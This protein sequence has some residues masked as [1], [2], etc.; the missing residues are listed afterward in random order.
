MSCNVINLTFRHVWSATVQI[1]Q[2][3]CAVWSKSSLGTFWIAKDAKFLHVN[4]KV[5][6]QT[7]WMWKLIRV[8]IGWYV[9]SLS[10]HIFSW[11]RMHSDVC[12]GYKIPYLPKSL[13][14]FGLIKKM[15]NW[16]HFSYFFPKNRIWHFMQI[17]S[18]GDNLHKMS[19]AVLWE[20]KENI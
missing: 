14:L 2:H 8:F 7:A 3:I 15:T 4:N 1:S 10:A 9:F 11:L 12:I 16:W 18:T 5:S 6:N 19:N 20:N 13:P 17:V